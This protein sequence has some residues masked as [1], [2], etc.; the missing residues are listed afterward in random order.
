MLLSIAVVW[1]PWDRK[2]RTIQDLGYGDYK[3]FV[4]VGAAAIDE[5]VKL[6]RGQEWKG[7]QEIRVVSS[8]Y[9]SGKLILIKC[10][11]HKKFP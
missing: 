2:S 8:S 11:L 5:L 7:E 9:C 10:S 4:C 3:K 6:E 1:N